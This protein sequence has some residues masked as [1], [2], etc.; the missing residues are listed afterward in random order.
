[1]KPETIEI[2]NFTGRLT[3]KLNGDL[4]S[5]F[6]KF[7]TSHGYDIFSKPGNLTWFEAP[8]DLDPS[9]ATIGLTL[10]CAKPSLE[11][12]NIYIYAIGT[13]YTGNLAKLFK[14]R[15]SSLG[16][17]NLDSVSVLA[18]LSNNDFNYGGSMELFGATQKIYFTGESRLTSINFDGSAETNLGGTFSG[19]SYHPTTQFLGNLYVG[20]KANMREVNASGVEL[21][22]SVL[23]PSLPNGTW[24]RDMDVTPDGDYISLAS[25]FIPPEGQNYG[26]D[27]GSAA[28]GTGFVFNWN[29]VDDGITNYRTFPSHAVTAFETYMNN[30]YLFSNES[31]GISFNNGTN[32]VKIL[33]NNRSV[34]PNSIATDGNYI[35]W[36]TTEVV[37][38]SLKASMYYFGSLDDETPPGLWRVFRQ[39]SAISGGFMFTTPLNIL[40]NNKYQTL[41]ASSGS[42]ASLGYGKHYFSSYELDSGAGSPKFKLYRFLTSSAGTGTPT[43]GVYETQTQ[44][45]SKRA[46]IKQIRVYTEPTVVNNGFQMDFIGSDGAVIPN[47]TSSYAFS[48]GTNL[49]LLQGSL[50]RIDFSPSMIPVYALGVRITN[51][52]TTNMTI[53]K[54]EIDWLP[55]GK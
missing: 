52:G 15:P 31:I 1:M 29:G 30:Q 48:A 20:D 23:S 3:R 4:N 27:I 54:I 7:D 53:K 6:A 47:G 51:T 24:I 41:S 26:G 39:T 5:G 43:L 19:N 11:A 32:N 36:V 21:R 37:G 40:V 28:T 9:D 2:S 12:G 8:A 42:I 17:P 38:N 46:T 33:P 55:Q 25:S 10:V 22:S 14:I 16:Q 13:N 45:F 50:E 18:T 44:L 35:S 34:I 49:E